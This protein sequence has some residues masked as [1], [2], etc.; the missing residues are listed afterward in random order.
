[1]ENANLIKWGF[2]IAGTVIVALLAA[3]FTIVPGGSRGVVTT[4][5]KIEPD[6]LGEGFHFV[7]PFIQGVNK[8][9]VRVDKEEIETDAASK[10]LQQVKVGATIN[11][12]LEPEAVAAAYQK[13]GSLEDITSRFVNP[14]GKSVIKIQT[15]QKNAE[16]L[17]QQRAILQDSIEAALRKEL[18]KEHIILSN[19]SITNIDF[20]A[21]FNKAI[22]SK[23]VAQQQ[24]QQAAYLAERA[25]NE[26]QALREKAKG[27]ADAEIERARGSSEAQNLMLKTL[28][29][30]ILQR[31]WIDKWDGKLPTVTTGNAPMI[32]IPVGG[33]K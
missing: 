7:I 25:K 32:Q 6:V 13:Y 14:M 27:E 31:Q 26:A 30:L 9:S 12:S 16:E 11:W 10:D 21:D 24:A 18:S 17:L 5:G 4:M 33:D 19:V 28:T 1:M 3:P 23:Q 20:S 8:I 2:I 29:P 15:A 22:E